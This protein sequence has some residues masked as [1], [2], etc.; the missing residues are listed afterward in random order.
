MAEK[1]RINA[2]N[3]IRSNGGKIRMSEAI[4]S[5]I[6]RTMLYKLL[7]DGIIEKISRGIYRLK[8]LEL[9]SNPDLVTVAL[10]A[11]NAVICLISALSFHGITT[12]IPR[13]VHIA[14]SK[15]SIAPR[16]YEPPVQVHWLSEETF[17]MGIETHI[18]DD[19]TVKI[20]NPEKTIVDCFKFRDQIGTDCLIEAVK[21]YHARK[22]TDID[23]IIHYA[24]ICHVYKTIVP[25]IEAIL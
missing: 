7:E 13:K 24:R 19:V 18:I 14:I 10:R 16:I 25:Y 5:G 15:K 6:S 4:S 2:I 9:L 20:Y 11:P 22:K 12:Q 1:N 23:K 21:L 8:E 17:Q 3:I